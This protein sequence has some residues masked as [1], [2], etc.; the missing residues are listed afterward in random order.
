[1]EELKSSAWAKRFDNDLQNW[2]EDFSKAIKNQEALEKK[3]ETEQESE[4]PFGDDDHD[5]F[6]RSQSSDEDPFN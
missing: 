4:N 3:K 1:M 5:P 2:I 6:G